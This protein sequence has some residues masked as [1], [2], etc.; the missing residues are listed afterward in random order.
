LH[1]HILALNR[2]FSDLSS[3][4]L[5]GSHTPAKRGGEAFGYQGRKASE[6]TNTL[7]LADNSGQILAC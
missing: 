2:Q 3:I 6:T 5:D 1:W 7:F 4:Q